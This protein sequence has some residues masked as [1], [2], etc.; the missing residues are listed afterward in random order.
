M[1]KNDKLWIKLA[2][3]ML[4]NIRNME[5]VCRVRYNVNIADLDDLTDIIENLERIV[6]K[7]E[8][9]TIG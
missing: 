3:S 1:G 2:I 6:K 4:K 7:G 5:D 8:D 9:N